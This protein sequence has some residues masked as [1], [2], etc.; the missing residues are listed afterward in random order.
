MATLG[1]LETKDHRWRVEV[2]GVGAIAWYRLIGTDGTDRNLPSLTTLI[3]AAA[4][5]GLDMGDLH[6]LQLSGSSGQATRGRAA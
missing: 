6:E 4:T 1:V 5:V 3:H 2:G